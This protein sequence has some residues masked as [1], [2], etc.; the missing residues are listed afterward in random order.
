MTVLEIIAIELEELRLKI[1]NVIMRCSTR[2][3]FEVWRERLR[4]TNRYSK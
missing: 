3:E 2:K 4:K 1:K